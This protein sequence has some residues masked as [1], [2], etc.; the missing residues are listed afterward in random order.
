MKKS[1]GHSKRSVLRA[2]SSVYLA[3]LLLMPVVVRAKVIEQ[4]IAIIDGEPYTLS[5]LETYAKTKMNRSFPTGDLAKINP[6]DREV[7]E[8]FLTEK[9]VESEIREGGIK[10]G[11]EDVDQYIE[12]V[13]KSNRLSDQDL[14]TALSRE[15]QTLESYRASVKAE[16][17]KNELINRQVR[18]KVNVTN[19]DVERYYKLNAKNYRAPDRARIRHILLALP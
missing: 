6:S 15:G 11:D 8:Q 17:E 19:E 12:Q 1:A 9:L 3:L 18:K 14:K 10:V 16:L 2:A 13:K 7:L 5:N 4:L